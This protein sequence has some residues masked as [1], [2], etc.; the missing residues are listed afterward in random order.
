MRLHILSDLHTGHC[1]YGPAP[2]CADALVLPG[3]I[4][5]GASFGV[6]AVAADYL[7]AGLP[8]LY[9][10]GNPEFY[11]TRLPRAL[12]QL[13]RQCRAAGITLLANRTAVV[14][15]V[16]F[17]GATL[18]T[19]FCL[20]GEAARAASESRAKYG[21]SDFSCIFDGRGRTLAPATTARWH[22]KS[23]R[24][25]EAELA[26][27]FDGPSVVLSHHAPHRRSI[28]PRWAGHPVNPAFASDLEAVILRHAPALW[29]HGHVHDSF[30]YPVGATRVLANPRGYAKQ[31][32][33]HNGQARLSTENAAFN[34]RLVVSV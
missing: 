29:A 14:G 27:P 13:A 10:P 34:P 1:P 6:A 24:L 17:V 33:D 23:L 28:H 31:V 16:R 5:D 11:G 8:V 26:R 18:W 9:V 25:L 30:D 12:R 19:D 20:Y 3:D 7:A 21:I 4:A 2:V 22:A 15:G 32:L